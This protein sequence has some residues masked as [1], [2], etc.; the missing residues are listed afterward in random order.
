MLCRIM[1]GDI[2]ASGWSYGQT[3]GTG[4]F[5]ASPWSKTNPQRFSDCRLVMLYQGVKQLWAEFSPAEFGTFFACSSRT[6]GA[7]AIWQ[8]GDNGW[9][10]LVK[11]VQ[12]PP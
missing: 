4:G 2:F 5:S 7:M 3:D 10:Q 11:G 12:K 6:K 1:I 8:N 9:I